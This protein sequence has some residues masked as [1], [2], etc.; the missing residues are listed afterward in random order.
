MQIPFWIARA[1]VYG[2]LLV[3][4]GVLLLKYMAAIESAVAALP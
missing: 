4:V 1:V 3:M 2:S